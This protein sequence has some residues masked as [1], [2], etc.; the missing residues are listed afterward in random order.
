MT[1]RDTCQDHPHKYNTEHR[2][3]GIGWL[4]PAMVPYG[5]AALVRTARQQVLTAAYAAHPE[6]FVRRPPAPPAVAD[7][8]WI[9][10]PVSNGEPSGHCRTNSVATVGESER[11]R[12]ARSH[13]LEGGRHLDTPRT[14]SSSSAWRLSGREFDTKCAPSVS[15]SR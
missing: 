3:G 4:T 10:P 6:R 9:N 1:D 15:Q 11:F 8:V 5:Q 12:G 7:A 2:H 13:D 14:T